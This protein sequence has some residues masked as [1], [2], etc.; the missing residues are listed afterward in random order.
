MKRRW[1]PKNFIGERENRYFL[2]LLLIFV[3]VLCPFMRLYVP[4]FDGSYNLQVPKN[5]LLAHRYATNI[6]PFDVMITTGYPVLIPIALGFFV[7]GVSSA[8]ATLVMLVFFLLGILGIYLFYNSLFE[9]SGSGIISILVFLALFFLKVPNSLLYVFEVIGEFPSVI[10]LIFSF[11]SLHKYATSEKQDWKLLLFA[12]L[13]FGLSVETKLI[14]ILALPAIVMFF[15]L[16]ARERNYAKSF[17]ELS[18]F[19]ASFL[20][21]IILFRVFLISQLG[22]QKFILNQKNLFEFIKGNSGSGVG[23]K[24]FSL[25]EMF[26]RHLSVINTELGISTVGWIFLNS[27][28]VFFFFMLVK[29]KMY[30]SASLV[31]FFFTY[32]V[33]WFFLNGSFW[34]RHYIPGIII[35]FVLLGFMFC[36]LIDESRHERSRVVF[37]AALLFGVAFSLNLIKMDT[38]RSTFSL[39]RYQKESSSYYEAVDFIKKHQSSGNMYYRGWWQVPELALFSEKPFL[40]LDNENVDTKSRKNYLILTNLEKNLAPE[41]YAKNIL[42]C[43][44]RFVFVNESYKICKLKQGAI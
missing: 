21:P 20:L 16:D 44:E 13:I 43:N 11:I 9:L 24:T 5:I 8:V 37:S 36:S 34:L 25:T 14:M 15:I 2:F 35:M 30:A 26:V 22:F 32:S 6:A 38:V 33:W 7:F 42:L 23:V 12:G 27:V 39:H 41:S 40:N 28:L 10:F 29:K 31:L 18:G 4:G 1:N 17:K 19:I 3:V